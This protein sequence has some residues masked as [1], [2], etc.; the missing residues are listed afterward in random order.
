MDQIQQLIIDHI[1]LWTSSEN[2][3]NTGKGRSS[4]NNKKIYG[5]QKLRELILNLAM[6]GKLSK[7]DPRDEPAEKLIIK[8]QQEEKNSYSFDAQNSKVLPS[9]WKKVPLGKLFNIVYGKSLPKS[10]LTNEGYDVFGANGI[11]GKYSKYH[12]SEPQLL[13]SCRGAY[14]GKPNISPKNC[15]VTSN[16]LILENSWLNL[17]KMFFFYALSIADKS[18]IVTGS[19]QPQ[20]T[21]TNLEPFLVSLPP[22]N[23]QNRIVLRVDELMALCDNIEHQ[24]KNSQEAHEKL[25]KVL[26]ET[27]TQSKDSKEF[28]ENWQRIAD[29]FETLFTTEES[30][31]ELKKTLAQLAVMGKLVPQDSNDEPASELIKRIQAE[32]TKLIEKEKLKNQKPLQKIDKSKISFNLPSGWDIARFGEVLISR[33]SD[34]KP[35]SSNERQS[36]QGDFDYYGASGV[37]DKIN[38]YIFDKPLLLIGEDGANLINR[39]TPIAFIARGKYW[40]NNHAHVLDGISESFLKYIELYINS[41]DLR[42]YVTG[43]AQPKMNQAKMNSIILYLPPQKEQKRISKKL[44]ELFLICDELKSRIQQ[45][46]EKQKQITDVLVSNALN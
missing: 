18:N 41:I 39:S 7:Q 11:I 16:S 33:D 25:G 29:H 3:K 15:F 43:T 22:L 9:G 45:A 19:A 30:I 10:K 24:Y 8:V 32:K 36:L 38:D 34:R 27:L 31:D 26:L 42:P 4:S 12:Y 5:L 2:E 40:V 17:N 23:E 28:K 46:R 37:I 1:S 20:V 21:T 6:E 14:S 35:I 44:D 13:M